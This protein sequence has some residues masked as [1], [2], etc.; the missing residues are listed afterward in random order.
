[1]KKFLNEEDLNLP[2]LGSNQGYVSV[3]LAEGFMV[4]TILGVTRLAHSG[5]LR[6]DKVVQRI[7]GWKKG[8][9][10]QSTLT[11]F[12]RKFGMERNNKVFPAINRFWF[13]QLKLDKMTIDLDSNVLTRYGVREGVA[14]RYNPKHLGMDRLP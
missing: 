2:I 10:Y 13:S 4:S 1:L 6:N 12:F 9:R 14:K 8:M 7:F 3:D 11:H 5:I